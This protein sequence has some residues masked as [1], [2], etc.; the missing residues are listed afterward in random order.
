MI[1]SGLRAASGPRRTPNAAVPGKSKLLSI[2]KA[3]MSHSGHHS[4]IDDLIDL[5]GLNG[6]DWSFLTRTSCQSETFLDLNETGY[7]YFA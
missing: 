4:E 6:E 1:G 7:Q 3:G 2:E 5:N